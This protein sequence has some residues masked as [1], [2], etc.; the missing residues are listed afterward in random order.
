M[1]RATL[2]YNQLQYWEWKFKEEITSSASRNAIACPRM[3]SVEHI[4]E[5]QVRSKCA[6]VTR[7]T[8]C[9]TAT[10]TVFSNEHRDAFHTCA[11]IDLMYGNITMQ[12]YQQVAESTLDTRAILFLGSQSSLHD[13]D[14][15]SARETGTGNKFTLISTNS[16]SCY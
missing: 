7:R 11:L 1:R 4:T 13:E 15:L 14:V 2:L 10:Y 6:N 5:R 9:S 16:Q 12:R 3:D 8:N